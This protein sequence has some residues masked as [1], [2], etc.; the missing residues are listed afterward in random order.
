MEGEQLSG[1]LGTR[2][3]EAWHPARRALGRARGGA[4]A[5]GARPRLLGPAAAQAAGAQRI[6]GRLSRPYFA[7]G[8]A[9][10]R[11]SHE[12]AGPTAL[13]REASAAGFRGPAGPAYRG[14]SLSSRPSPGPASSGRPRPGRLS[15]AMAAGGRT[16]HWLMLNQEPVTPRPPAGPG[17]RE[18]GSEAAPGPRRAGVRTCVCPQGRAAH[19]GTPVPGRWPRAQGPGLPA[20]PAQRCSWE[21]AAGSTGPGPLWGRVEAGWG[22][23]RPGPPALRALEWGPAAV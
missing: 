12:S 19:G 5:P 20:G 4:P 14:Q 15:E 3:T 16:W 23:G 2:R 1:A 7:S 21:E 13:L 22:G 6:F 10:L 18:G 17:G 9:T 11:E 8:W